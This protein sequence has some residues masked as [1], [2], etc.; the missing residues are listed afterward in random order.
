PEP[1]TVYFGQPPVV[2]L[3]LE[4]DDL[5][6]LVEEPGIDAREA[7]DLVEGE[8][9]LERVADVPD[10]LRAGLAELALQG[11]AVARALVQ[12]VDADLQAAQRLLERL[13]EGAADRHHLAD[14]LHLRGEAVVRL[15][16]LLEREPR[17]LGDD[18]V[19]GRLE[20]RRG[21]A[22]DRKST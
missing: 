17:H 8:A 6:D 19:D 5:A 21:R 1:L 22:A 16:E 9:V 10:A 14:R 15:R 4:L 13:L 11:L 3:H 20:R 18:V 2:E 7:V 12:A